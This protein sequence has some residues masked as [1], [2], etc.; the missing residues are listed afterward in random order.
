MELV[1]VEARG[2]Q[3]RAQ[4]R[5]VQADPA[6]STRLRSNPAMDRWPEGA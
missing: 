2:P 6:Q 1:P 3:L 5:A 4:G